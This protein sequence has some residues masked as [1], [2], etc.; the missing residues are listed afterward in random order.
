MNK[1]KNL[2]V[3]AANVLF[4]S[5]SAYAQ[6]PTASFE[7]NE[8]TL[9]YKG[10]EKHLSNVRQ[11]T[12]GGDNAEAYFSFDSK[13]ITFQVNN[14][15]WGTKCDQIYYFELSAGNMKDGAPQ[16]ISTGRGRTTCSYFM[17]GNK[18][19]LYASTHE[20]N[21]ECPPAP[22]KR[23]GRIHRLLTHG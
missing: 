2:L 13:A 6:V 15:E 5:L 21:D 12:F 1:I 9:L 14:S 23:P 11:L 3:I 18:Q 22:A 17:P 8:S 20:G 7:F 4:F 10:E 19:I 16:L